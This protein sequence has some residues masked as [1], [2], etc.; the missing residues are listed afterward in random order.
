[1]NGTKTWISNSPVAHLL[2]VWARVK[3]EGGAV[4]GFLVERDAVKIEEHLDDCRSLQRFRLLNI[5]ELG[6]RKLL[7]G[8]GCRYPENCLLGVSRRRP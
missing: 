7:H 6:L 3:D 2:L 1:M 8:L 4:R 5:M